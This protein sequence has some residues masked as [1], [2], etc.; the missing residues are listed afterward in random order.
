VRDPRFNAQ[1]PYPSKQ[2]GN[3]PNRYFSAEDLHMAN[4]AQVKMLNI[5]NQKN[6]KLKPQ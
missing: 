3:R 1:H 4:K 2:R 5:T 6:V